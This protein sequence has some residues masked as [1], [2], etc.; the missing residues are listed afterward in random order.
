MF[1]HLG[2]QFSSAASCQLLMCRFTETQ[3]RKATEKKL[4]SVC[5]LN[6]TFLMD[7][8]LL[9]YL[10]FFELLHF[11]VSFAL[12]LNHCVSELQLAVHYRICFVSSL[13]EH[14]RLCQRPFTT[15]IHSL[16]PQA[17]CFSFPNI[18]STPHFP[19]PSVFFSPFFL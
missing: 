19:A 4:F 2:L 8:A 5:S 13:S 14:V 11:F 15:V 1:Y 7:L 18:N 3:K 9:P 10:I 6:Y 17:F 12:G 16:V